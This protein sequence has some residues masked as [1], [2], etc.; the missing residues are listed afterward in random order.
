LFFVSVPFFILTSLSL[1]E[2]I[3]LL[4]KNKFFISIFAI[5][6]VAIVTYFS[7]KID[8]YLWSDITKAPL[9]AIER[10]QYI[11]EYP[12]GYGVKEAVQY[13]ANEALLR[14]KEIFVIVPAQ[15]GDASWHITNIYFAK[16]P[17]V[18]VVKLQSNGEQ[19]FAK[20]QEMSKSSPT[21]LLITEPSIDVQEQLDVKRLYKIAEIVKSFPKPGG[22]RVMRVWK[23]KL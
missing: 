4:G 6:I 14:H 20:I 16:N 10:L 22:K 2:C 1:Y 13:I 12:S 17:L 8:Y 9:P 7:L 11:E 23:V 19:G 18:K 21:F 5:I 3:T 15:T